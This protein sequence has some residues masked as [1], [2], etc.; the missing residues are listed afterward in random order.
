VPIKTGYAPIKTCMYSVNKNWCCAKKNW[1]FSRS[2]LELEAIFETLLGFE[3]VEVAR[4]EVDLAID[5]AALRLA[6]HLSNDGM[7]RHFRIEK[8]EGASKY[9]P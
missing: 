8:G 7:P 2:H 5:R 6:T 3:N 9:W 1:Y 4:P